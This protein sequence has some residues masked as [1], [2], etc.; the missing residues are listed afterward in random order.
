[1]QS[2][3]KESGF[4]EFGDGFGGRRQMK[5]GRKRKGGGGMMGMLGF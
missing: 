3:D 5:M 1:M 2:G 4:G